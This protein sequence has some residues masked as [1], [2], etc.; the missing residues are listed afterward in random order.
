[1]TLNLL[2]PSQRNPKVSAYTML[3]GNFDFNATPLAPPGIKVIIHEKPAQRGSWDPH[4]I[5]GW[6][7]GP[8]MEH[9]RCY[10]VFATKTMAE[11][12]SDTVEFFPETTT[13]PYMSS[14]DI[15]IQAASDLTHALQHPSPANP[16]AP[17]GTG[18]L[19][20]LKQLAAI[21]QRNT[22]TAATPPRG[23]H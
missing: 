14:V 15:A 9:Y 7:L 6:Y 21:F 11:R 18:Q 13:V 16:F 3:E 2:R 17:I 5:D 10:T 19:E 8:A 12:T 22:N 4:G 23:C 1:M 20:A